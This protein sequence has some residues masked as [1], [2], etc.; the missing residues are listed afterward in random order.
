MRPGKIAAS[1][2]PATCADPERAADECA[3]VD[4]PRATSSM[5]ALRNQISVDVSHSPVEE[6]H[7]PGVKAIDALTGLRSRRRGAALEQAIH[8]A[9]FD[10]LADVGYAGLT[11]DAVAARARTGKASIYRR[12]PSKLELVMDALFTRLA[13]A[14]VTDEVARLSADVDTRTALLRIGRQ[15]VEFV[16]AAGEAVRAVGCEARRDPNLAAALNDRMHHPKHNAML[17]I[18]RRG[19]ARGEVRPDLDMEMVAM[20]LPAMLTHQI[21]LLS[22]TICDADIERLVDGVVMPLLAIPAPVA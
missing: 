3:D 19:V 1:P 12:W 17:D 8:D 7:C 21:L 9:V 20:V 6:P 11:I 13:I 16:G 10:E 4:E 22:R 18:F 2:G 5:P 15:I 14:D